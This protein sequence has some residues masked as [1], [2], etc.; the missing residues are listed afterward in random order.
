LI[1]ELKI[2]ADETKESHENKIDRMGSFF[3]DNRKE[4]LEFMKKRR[5]SVKTKE[6]QVTA[7]T[8]LIINEKVPR[9]EGVFRK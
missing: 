1:N 8:C 2:A 3:L 4:D 9:R 5:G 7:R 6:V